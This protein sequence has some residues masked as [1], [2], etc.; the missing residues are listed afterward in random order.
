MATGKNRN[1]QIAISIILSLNLL[2]TWLFLKF[3]LPVES[4]FYVKIVVTAIGLIFRLIY[5]HKQ[6]AMKFHYYLNGGILPVIYVLLVTQPFYFLFKRF[7]KTDGIWCC[8]L[9]TCVLEII[10]V[11]SIYYAGMTQNERGFVKNSILKILKIN[12]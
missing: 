6:A 1:Y 12:K 11:F 7:Y 4:I 5:A 8:F 9:L 3:E 10:L 2:L